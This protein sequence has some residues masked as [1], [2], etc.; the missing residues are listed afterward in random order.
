MLVLSAAYYTPWLKA[1]VDTDRFE[2]LLS[3]TVTFL[4]RLARISPT[5]AIDCQILEKV[6]LC[7]FGAGDQKHVYHNE[8]EPPS[9]PNSTTNSFG[10]ST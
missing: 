10:H 6:S 9:G 1:F 5:C 4:R 3:R 8:L 2:K 7:I